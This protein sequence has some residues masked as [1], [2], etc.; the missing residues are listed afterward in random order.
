ME[1]LYQ[2]GL[3][4]QTVLCVTTGNSSLSFTTLQAEE[5][6]SYC[7]EVLFLIL[8]IAV[9]ESLGW[10]EHPVFLRVA[11]KFSGVILGDV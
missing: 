3:V 10:C 4:D 2:C 11:T 5:K 7:Y 1:H 8:G 6:K 9:F